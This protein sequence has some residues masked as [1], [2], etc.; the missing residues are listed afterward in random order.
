MVRKY[1]FLNVIISIA[2]F[3]IFGLLSACGGGASGGSSGGTSEVHIPGLIGGAKQGVI[4]NLTSTVSLFAGNLPGADGTGELARF[5]SPQAQVYDGAG[6]LYVADTANNKIRKIVIATGVVTT[7]A[8][9]GAQG[10]TDGAGTVAKFNSPSGITTDG[11]NLYVA[12]TANNKIRKI[13]IATGVVSSMTGVANSGMLSGSADGAGTTSAS[14]Y[15]PSGITTDGINLYV[16]DTQNNKIRKIVIATDV[17]S[18]LAGTGAQGAADG[19]GTAATFSHP[20]GITSDGT[21]L[22]VTDMENNKIRRIAISTNDVSSLTGT[23]NTVMSPGS[24]NGAGSIATFYYPAGITNDGTN[25]YVADEINN[26]VRKITIA[27]NEVSTMAGTGA[28]GDADGAGMF[29]SFNFPSGIATDGNNLYVADR[30]NNKIRKIVIAT[31]VV[32]SLAGAVVG[33]DGTGAAASFNFPSGITTD[34]TSLYVAESNKIRKIAISTGEVASLAG[35]FLQVQGANDGAGTSAVFRNPS[36][37]TT[38]G[39]YLYVA[40][41]GNNKIR[42]VV[43]ATGVV[44]SL[45]GTAN[46]VMTAGATD[47]VGASALFDHPTGITTDGTNLYVVDSGNNKIR[48]IV[49][50]TGV[51]S[52]LTGTANTAM[53][54]GAADGAGTAATFSPYG[55]T[56]D[57]TNLYVSDFGNN[58]IRQIVI[59]TGVVSSLTGTA[60]TVM[61][62]GAADGAGTVAE[63]YYPYGVTT[64]GTSLFVT[65]TYNDTIR[66]IH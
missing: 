25:L 26:R 55:V 51:V 6:N 63:F 13:V 46:T 59:A 3:G 18:T 58:K 23:T 2:F 60:N 47:G 50:A 28:V 66:K 19:V 24:A 7:M 14:F 41:S 29:A 8:G 10:A 33:K 56:T 37:I 40:D 1:E 49:I 32:S 52:S 12:D 61:P 22:Y 45:T 21:N 53:T 27:T 38:E 9:T 64:D 62:S 15:F 36:G 57:G 17:V 16:V 44:S 31:G 35:S 48:K 4:L 65:D 34:G 54:S 30:I 42:K 5:N 43:I 20:S 11:T 39:N